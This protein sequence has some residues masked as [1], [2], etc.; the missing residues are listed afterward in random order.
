M[1]RGAESGGS[2]RPASIDH[3]EGNIIMAK[4]SSGSSLRGTKQTAPK[5]AGA[6]RAS[7]TNGSRKLDAL[8][9]TLD[10]RDLMYIPT[11]VE[12]P[13]ILPLEEYRA[14]KVPILDQGQEG[15]CTGFGL[16]TV[17]NFLLRIRKQVPDKLITSPRMFY[18]M[19][20]KYD[21]WP[22]ENY[23]G[24]SA[25]GAMK[26]W[27]KHGVCAEKD[28]PYLTDAQADASYRRLTNTRA[29]L[30]RERPLGAYFRV[31]HKNLV[32]MHSAIAE[33]RILYATASVHEGWNLVKSD[34]RIPFKEKSIGG[35][36]FAIVAYD[37]EGFWIQ[38]SWG[39][40]WGKQ[41]FCHITYDDWLMNASDVWVARLGAP[42]RLKTPEAQA[43]SKSAA[44]KQGST[45]SFSELRPHI[46]SIG[47]DGELRTTGTFGTSKEDVRHI[48]EDD[49]ERITKTWKSKR[50][51]L[52]AHGGLTSED[53]AIQRLADLRAALLDS[54]VYP[55]SFI[56]RTDF[57]STV[58][59]IVRD[60]M[61][62][63]RPEGILDA[64]KDFMLD[65]LDDGLEPVA[66]II[67]GKVLWD[68]MKENGLAATTR[69][70]GGGR[71]VLDQ[72]GALA[73][74]HRGLEI[75]LAGH[76]AGSIFLAPFIQR[77]TAPATGG[78]GLSAAS[79]AL[80]APAATVELFK[81]CY[82]PAIK[83]G[84]IERFALFT[85]DDRTERD[86]NCA[87]TYHKSL[88][89]LVSNAFEA[90]QRIPLIRDGVPIIGMEK[91]IRED[92]ELKALFERPNAAWVLA[93]NAVPDGQIEASR[94]RHHGDFDDDAP[95]LRA[96]LARILD[97]KANKSE[98]CFQRSAS[99]AV[100]MRQSLA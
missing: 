79:C 78:L 59:N 65:R 9:D 27:H 10:F 34:G 55:I 49:F 29:E 16:A 1:K 99:S 14:A 63:R 64:G 100:S 32:A 45:Y 2:P 11:L 23:S 20:K 94:A 7:A 77:L 48:F 39:E 51:L 17:A 26:G 91:F 66:R 33:T 38:N 73:A 97:S 90:K 81:Q 80:W 71:L 62:R 22:G 72:V 40:D 93:P 35:H 25:R 53:S 21:E 89:Y 76:S 57:W 75:H 41:G 74:K 4:R 5:R 28:W 67:G 31:N 37:R 13:S 12:V 83:S 92:K 3:Q 56:W 36:A 30:A 46:V 44:A 6:K 86:D 88:L 42:V 70:E 19:A 58:T 85:L 96:T 47:N 84:A 24:S 87:D 18:E 68:E 60:A 95:T 61:R 69:A 43:V 50:L 82:M 52:Y 54:E 15:A 98:F 8:P